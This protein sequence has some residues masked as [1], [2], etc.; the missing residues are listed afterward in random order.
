MICLFCKQFI[1]QETWWKPAVDKTWYFTT[2]NCVLKETGYPHHQTT[3]LTSQLTY[4]RTQNPFSAPNN[5][6]VSRIA[7]HLM[8][9]TPTVSKELTVSIS[10]QQ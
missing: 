8:H 2:D 6:S 10:N 1:R 7:K 4:L 5:Q 9:I 3:T